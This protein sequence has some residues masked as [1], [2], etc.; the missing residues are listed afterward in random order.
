MDQS[1]VQILASAISRSEPPPA[2][3]LWGFVKDEVYVRP[4]PTT[5]NNLKDHN[6]T[7][8]AKTYQPLLQ[9]VSH[10]VEYHLEA[11]RAANGAHTELA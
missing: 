8:T 6:Q 3:F 10:E 2:L 1:G 5:L 9:N 4:I 7:V 11:C